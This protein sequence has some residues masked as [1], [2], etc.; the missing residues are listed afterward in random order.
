MNGNNYTFDFIF[1]NGSCLFNND[2][3][4]CCKNSTRP[5]NGCYWQLPFTKSV[6]INGMKYMSLLFWEL[7][8]HKIISFPC[9]SLKTRAGLRLEPDKL[10]KWK[11]N[12]D[13]VSFYKVYQAVSSSIVNQFLE[14]T[15]SVAKWVIV[16]LVISNSLIASSTVKAITSIFLPT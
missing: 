11:W 2:I 14:S 9:K 13:N 10:W 8:W 16:L 4:I 12:Y 3:F 6:L 1:R 5:Y 7:I 15:F